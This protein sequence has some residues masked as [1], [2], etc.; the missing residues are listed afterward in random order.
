MNF[1]QKPSLTWQ[2]FRDFIVSPSHSRTMGI[3]V[4]LILVS[5]VSL[6]VVLSQQQQTLKQRAQTSCTVANCNGNVCNAG[7]VC[8]PGISTSAD[9]YYSNCYCNA[10]IGPATT[11]EITKCTRFPY[12]CTGLSDACST[13]SYN[14]N[15]GAMCSGST[16]VTGA[17][18]VEENYPSGWTCVDDNSQSIGCWYSYACPP[19]SATTS[20]TCTPAGGQCIPMAPCVPPATH[21]LS[22]SCGNNPSGSVCCSIAAAPKTQTPASSFNCVDKD[23]SDNE[24]C[25]GRPHSDSAY[26][27]P[28]GVGRDGSYCGTPD[29]KPNSEACQSNNCASDLKCSASANPPPAADATPTPTPTQTPTTPFSC[30]NQTGTF[31]GNY[32]CAPIIND[33]DQCASLTG[34]DWALHS[35]SYT[36]CDPQSSNSKTSACCKKNAP[37]NNTALTLT[38]N[39]QDVP[40]TEGNLSATLILYNLT[41]NS[42]VAGAPATQLFTKTPI[43]GKQYSANIALTNLP[44]DKYYIVVKKDKMLA[45]AVFTVSNAT[46]SITVPT[47][48]LVFGDVNNDN[49]IN[50]L[51]YNTFKDCWKKS[52]ASN[53]SCTSSDFDKSGQVDQVDY[54][55]FLRGFSTWSKEGQ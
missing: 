43:P 1:L 3:L 34:G 15:N 10:A 29:K 8:A 54:N 25:V 36:S 12:G 24:T 20:D 26:C 35:K 17:K 28:K 55:T 46:G 6:T 41:T 37:V 9:P 22:Y 45:K 13:A 2:K 16:C 50:T 49:D 33:S 40:A 31:A 14:I 39:T 18:Y 44:Q 7:Q 21:N 53:L 52:T 42:P 51:D 5:A 19:A 27:L 30:V 4:M 32:Q 11:T 23:C 38:L 48:T 47:T